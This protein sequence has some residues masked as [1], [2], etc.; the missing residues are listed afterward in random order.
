[1]TVDV[2]TFGCRLNGLESEVMRLRAEEAGLTDA[3]L[4]NTCAVTA[5]AVRQAR[6]A[7]RRA[8]REHPEKR[9]VVAGCAAQIDPASFV[10]MPEVDRVL[11]NAE[12]LDAA[13]YD[14]QSRPA[15]ARRRHHVRAQDRRSADRSPPAGTRAPSSRSRTAATTA[16]PSASSPTV[17]AI[18]ARCRWV[19]S[20]NMS[21][22]LVESGYAEVVLTGVDITAYG[23]DL[24]DGPRLGTLV[25]ALLRGR[26]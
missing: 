15:H 5:E 8:K 10:R 2:I 11:G 21:A 13:S 24:A 18:R 4:V 1:M 22:A 12:K 19:R 14:F 26:A 6:Q 7:I 23:V 3:I 17:A 16:A 25:R 9:I 20:S